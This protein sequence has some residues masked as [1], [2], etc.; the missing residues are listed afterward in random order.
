MCMVSTTCSE[1]GYNCIL[2]IL[3]NKMNEAVILIIISE[4]ALKC[5]ILTT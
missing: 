1:W 2:L 4:D 3:Q 5:R